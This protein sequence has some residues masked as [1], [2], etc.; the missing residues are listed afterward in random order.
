MSAYLTGLTSPNGQSNR[1]L[2]FTAWRCLLD[3]SYK[4]KW[5]IKQV[6]NFLPIFFIIWSYAWLPLFQIFIHFLS[7]LTLN[8]QFFKFSFIFH[9][10][11]P[12]IVS[13]LNF[14]IWAYP[15]LP[16]KLILIHLPGLTSKCQ[17]GCAL[18][19]PRVSTWSDLPF[20]CHLDKAQSI[21]QTWS[22]SSSHLEKSCFTSTTFS[23]PSFFDALYVVPNPISSSYCLNPIG[24]PSFIFPHF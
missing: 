8:C 18:T 5:P 1:F 19:L 22:P 15:Q 23:R 17:F 3:W 10:D 7:R 21:Q 16:V 20:W 9:L 12:S 2:M 24:F 6:F 4:S 11:L 14:F 13:S